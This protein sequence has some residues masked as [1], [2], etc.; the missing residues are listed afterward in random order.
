M[1]TVGKNQVLNFTLIYNT[2]T[3]CNNSMGCDAHFLI[4]N[5]LTHTF[6]NMFIHC[7]LPCFAYSE[8]FLVK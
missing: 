7:N 3:Y 2:L 5:T 4:H 6:L 8:D 1:P